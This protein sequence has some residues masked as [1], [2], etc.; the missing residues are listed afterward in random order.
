MEEKKSFT[1]KDAGVDIKAADENKKMIMKLIKETYS[2]NVIPDDKGIGA[3]FKIPLGYKNPVLISGSDGVGTKLKI[4][5]MMKRHDSVGIDLVAMCANDIIRRGAK[6]LFFM[7]YIASGKLDQNK[8]NE[9]IKGIVEGCRQAGCSLIGGETAQMPDFYKEG[10]YDL[11]GFCIGIAEKEK[12]ITGDNIKP[13]DLIIGLA[14]SGLHSNGYSLAR[15]VLLGKY[16]VNDTAYDNKKIGDELIKPTRIYVKPIIDILENNFDNIKGLAHITGSAFN[17]LKRLNSTVG[18][19][20]DKLLKIP[21]IFDLIQKTGNISDKEM[22]STFNMGIG[23]IIIAENAD[24][25]DG[26][27]EKYGYKAEVIGIVDDSK[28]VRIAEKRIKL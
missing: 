15:K 28:K 21:K 10:E 9:I 19:K 1:Y 18:F 12:I 25:I 26:F 23:F 22:F 3:M 20:I 11:S 27:E 16:D 8:V 7:D 6:P 24:F 2:E 13:G 5:F 4:A 17:K 14:S